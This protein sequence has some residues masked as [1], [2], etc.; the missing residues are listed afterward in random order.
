MKY[1]I[2]E[3]KDYRTDSSSGRG[4]GIL[5]VFVEDPKRPGMADIIED[6]AYRRSVTLA[7]YRKDPDLLA[8]VA[9]LVDRPVGSFRLAF[10]RY[11]GCSMCPCSPGI[12]VVD[13]AEPHKNKSSNLRCVWVAPI[14]DVTVP[15]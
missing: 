12:I 13:T 6:F 1:T 3:P 4:K 11:A 10:S 9:K 7:E 8:E 5:I 2:S 14:L 15:A